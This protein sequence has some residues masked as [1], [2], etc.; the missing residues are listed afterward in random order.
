MR[1]EPAH[2][3]T[4][5]VEL[6]AAAVQ[7]LLEATWGT[8]RRD[9]LYL[10]GGEQQRGGVSLPHVTFVLG[11]DSLESPDPIAQAE[12][13][14]VR[15]LVDDGDAVASAAEIPMDH[16]GAKRQLPTVTT[17][18]AAAEMASAVQAAEA[19]DG[20]DSPFEVRLLRV[21]AM[22]LDALWLHADDDEDL[23]WPLAGPR[24]HRPDGPMR[25]AEF[26]ER[27]RE[28]ANAWR[29]SDSGSPEDDG[30]PFVR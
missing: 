20:S 21:P 25:H 17:G 27:L 1:L 7:E 26:V 14:S 19:I 5:T 15:F 3:P 8:P 12:A 23:F 9:L 2:V 22:H 10:V 13:A 28:M 18:G 6:V 30:E 11:L 16:L 24:R 4:L 29:D